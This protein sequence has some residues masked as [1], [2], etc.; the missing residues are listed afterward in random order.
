[1]AVVTVKYFGNFS[2]LARKR[3]ERITIGENEN[4]GSLLK[5]LGQKYG[6]KAARSF[7]GE[8]TAFLVNGVVSER[9]MIL[10][11]GDELIIATL[12]GGG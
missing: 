6:W 8:M 2:M 11:H 7:A 3:N 12:V 1:M 5:G 9:D 4:I 10:H